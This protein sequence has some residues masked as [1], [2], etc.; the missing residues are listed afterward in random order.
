[1]ANALAGK[2]AIV[3]GSSRGIGKSIAKAFAAEGALVTVTG[4]TLSSDDPEAFTAER[5]AREIEDAGGIAVPFQVDMTAP[6]G[7]ETMVMRTME[8]FNAVDVLVN[9]AGVLWRG[10]ILDTPLAMWDEVVGT[11][12]DGVHYCTRE[13]VPIMIRQRSGAVINISSG[14][15]QQ[16]GAQLSVYS[17]TK[18][19]LNSY[20]Q[21]LAA[22]V[23]D[24]GISVNA[25]NPG[26]TKTETTWKR[27]PGRDLTSVATSDEKKINPACIWLATEA[28][29][30]G[31]TGQ[32]VDEKEFGDAW[33]SR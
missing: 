5:T 9:N 29:E 30:A 2:V 23:K 14:A 27:W 10:G 6:A 17:V 3:T 19:A 22:E 15:A 21:N 8:R 20:S 31:F 28:A 1:M 11:N 26:F 33:P 25:L 4:R 12:L 18:A 16:T 24:F 7:I 32:I 13:V